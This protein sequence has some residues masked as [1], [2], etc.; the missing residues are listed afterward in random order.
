[1]QFR[2]LNHK[3]GCRVFVR[4]ANPSVKRRPQLSGNRQNLTYQIPYQ[5]GL[6]PFFVTIFNAKRYMPTFPNR[7]HLETHMRFQPVIK[8]CSSGS[9]HTK[10][11]NSEIPLRIDLVNR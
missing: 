9:L 11:E 10:N 4:R 1:M 3:T 6:F 8:S 7:H 2:L 5:L